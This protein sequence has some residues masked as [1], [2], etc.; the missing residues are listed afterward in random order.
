MSVGTHVPLWV[1][2]VRGQLEGITSVLYVGT[3]A[4]FMP[5]TLAASILTL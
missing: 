4:E 2:E 3:R 1:C 5:L